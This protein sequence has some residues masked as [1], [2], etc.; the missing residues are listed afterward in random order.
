MKD[1][2]GARRKSSVSAPLSKRH[3][4]NAQDPFAH[5]SI[6][7]SFVDTLN[8]ECM[9]RRFLICLRD[10]LP[11]V[12]IERGCD[13]I[14]DFAKRL[15]L[16]RTRRQ[17]QLSSYDALSSGSLFLF[18]FAI[19]KLRRALRGRKKLAQVVVAYADTRR[20]EIATFVKWWTRLEHEAQQQTKVSFLE[21]AVSH[22]AREHKTS[23]AATIRARRLHAWM[24]EMRSVYHRRSVQSDNFFLW[25]ARGQFAISAGAY[26]A[27]KTLILHTFPEAK[28]LPKLGFFSTTL[29]EVVVEEAVRRFGRGHTEQQLLRK[30]VA[31]RTQHGSLADPDLLLHSDYLKLV[32][33]PA[34]LRPSTDWQRSHPLFALAPSSSGVS[35]LS[36]KL[37]SASEEPYVGPPQA[38]HGAAETPCNTAENEKMHVAFAAAPP[39]RKLS[40]AHRIRLTALSKTVICM[41]GDKWLD[42]PLFEGKLTPMEVQPALR[43]VKPLYEKEDLAPAAELGDWRTLVNRYEKEWD[44]IHRENLPKSPSAPNSES[45]LCRRPPKKARKPE[46]VEVVAHR[47]RRRTP[48]LSV[49]I[50]SGEAFPLSAQRAPLTPRQ[51]RASVSH[52]RYAGSRLH[53]PFPAMM[54]LGVLSI[55][56]ADVSNDDTLES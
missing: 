6:V 27:M 44:K 35:M 32:I 36:P 47:Q 49:A 17:H 13:I 2:R 28:Y 50:T 20:T 41:V 29:R 34:E 19:L 53:V 25:V 54:Q 39:S 37:P 1:R 8:E 43:D 4:S 23:I 48:D 30:L 31:S 3:L 46:E 51:G 21:Y 5:I 45:R 55:P 16:Q 26:L 22:V 38:S 33:V 24:R 14:T 7:H 56:T 40:Q 52:S 42:H 10:H 12:G 9:D 18:R 15:L 11:F